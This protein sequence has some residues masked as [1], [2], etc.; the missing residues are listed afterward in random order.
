M[1]S[2]KQSKEGAEKEL[3]EVKRALEES[4]DA[5]FD[6]QNAAQRLR[7]SPRLGGRENFRKKQNNKKNGENGKV[8]RS[9]AVLDVSGRLGTKS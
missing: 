1:A 5:V 9:Y 6:E 3:E 7:Q 8:W 2:L 4:E